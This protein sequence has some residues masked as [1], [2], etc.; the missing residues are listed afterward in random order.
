LGYL[1]IWTSWER[2]ILSIYITIICKIRELAL[3]GRR[4]SISINLKKNSRNCMIT[5]NNLTLASSNKFKSYKIVLEK[6]TQI[7]Q[8][9]NYKTLLSI[10]IYKITKFNLGILVNRYNRYLLAFKMIFNCLKVFKNWLIEQV[11]TLRDNIKGRV[12]INK[13]HKHF[14]M[15]FRIK[16][17]RVK[18]S[19]NN[20]TI[21]YTT[22]KISNRI[23]SK[24]KDSL[25]K[26]I[27]HS[28]NSRWSTI[29]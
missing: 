22:L 25:E 19:I 16:F 4:I 3:R 8:C 11:M 24:W 27:T 1:R 9:K 29:M 14:F 15:E 28:F 26:S 2:K 18:I 23:W 12:L 17:I 5:N 21:I 6:K 10:I 7:W 20:M 13:F